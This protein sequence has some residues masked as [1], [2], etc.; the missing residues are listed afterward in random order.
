MFDSINTSA[1]MF[2]TINITLESGADSGTQM[3]RI[4]QLQT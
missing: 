4:V 2:V 1:E 3:A